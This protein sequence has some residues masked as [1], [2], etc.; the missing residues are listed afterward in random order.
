MP[1]EYELMPQYDT[2]KSFYGK[3]RVRVE[4]PV[5]LLVSYGTPVLWYDAGNG[6]FHRVWDG[7][8]S[9]TGRHIKEFSLQK[10][11]S[12]PADAVR[13]IDK[14]EW[15]TMPVEPVPSL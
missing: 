6:R 15:E 1:N 12:Q 7:W 10:R 8:S 4:G 2:R 11:T 13:G 5:E 3:A 14:R 9:T